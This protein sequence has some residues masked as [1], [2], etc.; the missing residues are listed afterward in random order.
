MDRPVPAPVPPPTY[1]PP[2]PT[3]SGQ[4]RAAPRQEEDTPSAQPSAS[5][6]WKK[7]KREV[8]NAAL[9]D[10][11]APAGPSDSGSECGELERKRKGHDDFDG[12]HTHPRELPQTGKLE[13]LR[14]AIF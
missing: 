7:P 2:Q 6:A 13:H 11:E 9:R 1:V 8:D 4:L 14:G 12:T 5:V 10:G 3:Q